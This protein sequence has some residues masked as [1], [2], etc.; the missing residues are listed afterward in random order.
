V[1]SCDPGIEF[2]SPP[3]LPVC[4]TNSC[5]VMATLSAYSRRYVQPHFA[6]RLRNG[7]SVLKFRFVRPGTGSQIVCRW[8]RRWHLPRL[9]TRPATSLHVT[10]RH[11]TSPSCCLCLAPHEPASTLDAADSYKTQSDLYADRCSATEI[12]PGA[13]CGSL[14]DILFITYHLCM[15]LPHM[16]FSLHFLTKTL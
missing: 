15:G 5:V 16:A 13:Q 14:R 3:L 6:L 12:H 2:P 9:P 10:S 11:V 7:T 1:G 8:R 4:N